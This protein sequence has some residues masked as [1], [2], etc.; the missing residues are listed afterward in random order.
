MLA[1]GAMNR[2][3]AHWAAVEEATELL[4]EERFHEALQVLRDVIRADPGNPYA[5]FFLGQ[6]LYEV[7]ELQPARDAYR[8]VLRLAPEHLG[9]RVSLIHVLRKLGETR[10]AVSEGLAALEQAP[11]DGDVLYALGLA[12][13][14]RGDNV[15]ARR[16]LEAFLRANPELETRIEVEGLLA[17]MEGPGPANDEN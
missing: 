1:R 15:A 13:L 7:G 17:A 8:A 5:F 14:A 10:D 6:A 11:T 12:Y 3:A 16:H 4:H 2:D 9:A